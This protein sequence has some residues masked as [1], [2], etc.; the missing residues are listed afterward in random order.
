[1]V[2]GGGGS[3]N[4]RQGEFKSL[5]SMDLLEELEYAMDFDNDN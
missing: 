5:P 4:E 2:S 3:G 1:M